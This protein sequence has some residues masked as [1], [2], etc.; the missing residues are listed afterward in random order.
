[1]IVKS[2]E[3]ALE[4]GWLEQARK[5]PTIT[6]PELVAL[7][8]KFANSGSWS[9]YANFTG[10]LDRAHK[11]QPAPTPE[12]IDAT[13]QRFRAALK[14]VVEGTFKRKLSRKTAPYSFFFADTLPSE[15]V[16]TWQRMADGILPIESTS[17][18]G[19]FHYLQIEHFAGRDPD[20]LCALVLF[21]LFD[22]A[23][24]FFGKL[25]QCH[26]R[27][28]EKFFFVVP[29]KRQ[30]KPLRLYCTTDHMKEEHN[31]ERVNRRRASPKK[32]RAASKGK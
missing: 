14:A 11:D 17:G 6:E 27:E 29:P 9:S 13:R 22:P 32:K 16:D 8:I 15:R 3:R 4:P 19:K 28:C 21:W 12:G 23:R 7:A 2:F 1:M 25:C 31:A 24:D 18:S 5:L 20:G 26:W 10:Q 30:G